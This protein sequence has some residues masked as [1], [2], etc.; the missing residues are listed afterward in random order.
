MRYD[1][2]LHVGAGERVELLKDFV[3]AY[4]FTPSL[5]V[6]VSTRKDEQQI[7]NSPPLVSTKCTSPLSTCW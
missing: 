2:D 1:G 7:N 4:L 3:Y 6:L 5:S